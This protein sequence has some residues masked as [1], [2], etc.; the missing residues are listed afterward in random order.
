[1][2]SNVACSLMDGMQTPSQEHASRH[3]ESYL[4]LLRILW[5]LLFIDKVL[6]ELQLFMLL[7]E[8]VYNYY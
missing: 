6:L 7:L 5:L 3:M 4:Y 1:M 8:L 2:E